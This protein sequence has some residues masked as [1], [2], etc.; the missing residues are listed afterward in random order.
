MVYP[1][2]FFGEVGSS[3]A[4]GGVRTGTT[5]RTRRSA[6]KAVT[7]EAWFWSA[8]VR[9]EERCAGPE[10]DELPLMLS[11]GGFLQSYSSVLAT[12]FARIIINVCFKQF[13]LGSVNF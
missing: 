10:R 11:A 3:E 13:H 4:C 5:V 8:K 12:K 1:L 9:V 7:A 2:H 6:E